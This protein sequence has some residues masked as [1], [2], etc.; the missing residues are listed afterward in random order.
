MKPYIQLS[1]QAIQAHNFLLHPTSAHYGRAR[2]PKTLLLSLVWI[3]RNKTIYYDLNVNLNIELVFQNRI[4]FSLSVIYTETISNSSIK[5]IHL[6][7]KN[8]T[9]KKSKG[10]VSY[11][12]WD[13]CCDHIQQKGPR[14]CLSGGSDPNPVYRCMHF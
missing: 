9:S 10:I 13:K 5:E 8:H 3:A 4:W 1:L 12:R 7:I 2:F 14:W 6:I 11:E